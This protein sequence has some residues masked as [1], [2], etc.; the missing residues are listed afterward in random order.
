MRV[1]FGL[2]LFSAA[3]LAHAHVRKL[4]DDPPRLVAPLPDKTVPV[5]SGV[6]FILS[7]P[8]TYF[9]DALTPTALL[10]LSGNVSVESRAFPS[11]QGGASVVGGVGA[12]TVSGHPTLVGGGVLRVWI[13]ATDQA[14]LRASGSFVILV[15]DDPPFVVTPIPARVA[16]LGQPLAITIPSGTFADILTP[17]ASLLLRGWLLPS[18]TAQGLAFD[19]GSPGMAAVRGTPTRVGGGAVHVTVRASDW[20]NQGVN[21]TFVITIVGAHRRRG[22]S[23]ALC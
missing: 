18:S 5:S 10:F 6:P 20:A 13:T 14:G 16:P 9:V 19:E 3:E 1:I 12:A 4:A 7:I 11:G 23:P 15:V 22:L 17:T 2:P 21:T 8:S